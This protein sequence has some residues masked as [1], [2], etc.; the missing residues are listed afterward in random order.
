MLDAVNY[1]RKG[2]FILLAGDVPSVSTNIGAIASVPWLTVFDFDPYS[3]DCGLLDS[4][5][6]LMSKSTSLHITTWK[7]IDKPVS[8]YGTNW[9]FIC[10]SRDDPESRPCIEITEDVRSWN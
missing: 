2:H 10:G 1:F 5:E 6:E 7:T 9:C 4:N 8:E 3:R